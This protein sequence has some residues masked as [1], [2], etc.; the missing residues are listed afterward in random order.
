[1]RTEQGQAGLLSLLSM[2]EEGSKVSK[3]P[4]WRAGSERD[5]HLGTGLL[6]IFIPLLGY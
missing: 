2:K 4:G 1:M 5:L 6:F 3:G